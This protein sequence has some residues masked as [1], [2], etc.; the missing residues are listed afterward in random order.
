MDGTEIIIVDD[1]LTDDTR[2]V[3]NGL[4]REI[5]NMRVIRRT[6]NEGAGRARNIGLRE[7]RG[8]YVCFLDADDAYSETV[9]AETAPLLDALPGFHAVSFHIRLVNCHRAVLPGYLRAIERESAANVLI[10]TEFARLL[11]GFPTS[12]EFHTSYGGQDVAFRVALNTWGLI[13][14]SIARRLYSTL[15]VAILTSTST[16][17]TS[18][19]DV[20]WTQPH[21]TCSVR[22][23]KIAR[24]G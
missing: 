4:A 14:D 11:G 13:I 16:W 15:C 9:F 23:L 10:R 22:R 20:D 7:A 8:Q 5:A 24:N 18:R 21:T 6:L 12:P 1:A 3:A 17:T 2:S 19:P